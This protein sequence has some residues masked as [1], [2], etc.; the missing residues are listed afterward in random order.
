MLE[1]TPEAEA[2]V[3][4]ALISDELLAFGPQTFFK[5]YS[6]ASRRFAVAANKNDATAD[7]TV[8]P[9]FEA[10]NWAVSLRDLLSNLGS[11]VRHRLA[12]ALGFA[13]DRVYHDWA[14]AVEVRTVRVDANVGPVTLNGETIEWYWKPLERLP[15]SG[16]RDAD[17][18]AYRDLLADQPVRASL[19]DLYALFHAQ[20][21]TLLQE[22]QI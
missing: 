14:A 12:S 21:A 6:D 5:G 2:Q 10:L 16:G 3:G 7:E 17:A 11:P 15:R 9:L 20:V 8:I 4:S 18:N 1:E 19:N 13:R 22:P